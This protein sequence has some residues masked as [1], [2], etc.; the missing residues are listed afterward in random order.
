MTTRPAA[1]FTTTGFH[2]AAVPLAADW[3]AA[4]R[5]SVAAISAQRRPEVVCEEGTDV[6]RALHGCH[7]FDPNLARLVRL[8][9]L[10]DLA[11]GL[12]GG[13]V[14]VYQ[15]KVNLKRPREGRAWPWHQDYAFWHHEDGMCRADAVNLAIFLDDV[16]DTN[17][18]LTVLSGSHRLGLL[19]PG[20]GADGPAGHD[21]QRDVSAKLTYTVPDG[22]VADLSRDHPP[23]RITGEAGTIVAFHPNIVHSSSDN[24]SARGR[25]ILLVTYNA[26][27]NPATRPARPEFL[28]SRDAVP[29][30]A[31]AAAERVPL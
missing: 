29:L 18:P 21:W 17:G 9:E 1:G 28:V 14:Y 3:L 22:T 23:V 15:F 5:E 31:L 11:T 19:G 10:L 24:L 27:T 2:R 25:A 13:E 8:P 4:V 12:V 7:R 16:D 26:V 20:R 6:V 30:A